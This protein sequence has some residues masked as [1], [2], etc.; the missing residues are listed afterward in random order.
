MYKGACSPLKCTK[1]EYELC[2]SFFSA[3]PKKLLSKDMWAFCFG[4]S[5]LSQPL[6]IH[7]DHYPIRHSSD[8]ED[9][10]LKRKEEKSCDHEATVAW[11]QGHMSTSS[12]IPIDII[13]FS[14]L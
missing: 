10:L 5:L 4:T 8:L 6:H 9:L 7:V 13:T 12:D 11:E 3:V 2:T 1:P 14:S